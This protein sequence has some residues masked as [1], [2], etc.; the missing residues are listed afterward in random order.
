MS[1]IFFTFFPWLFENLKLCEIGRGIVDFSHTISHGLR[2]PSC[3]FSLLFF[4]VLEI[5]LYFFKSFRPYLRIF[6]Q[7]CRLCISDD[8][9]RV[10]KL[11]KQSSSFSKAQVSTENSILIPG[12]CRCLNTSFRKKLPLPKPNLEALIIEVV[13]ALPAADQLLQ[14]LLHRLV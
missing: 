12:Y 5:Y 8:L 4:E 14:F 7:L 13:A 2:S 6:R 11:L 3:H 9:G 10:S 1:L